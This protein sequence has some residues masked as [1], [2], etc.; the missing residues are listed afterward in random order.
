MEIKPGR[1]V[2]NGLR[3]QQKPQPPNKDTQLRKKCSEFEAIFV[4]QMLKG[5]RKTVPQEGFLGKS[6]GE[7]TFRDLMD[8]EISKQMSET[9]KLGIGESLFRQLKKD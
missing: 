4:Q 9:G 5:M 3:N 8:V 6:S 7:E 2:P 1:P